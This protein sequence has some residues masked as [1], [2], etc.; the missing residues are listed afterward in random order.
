MEVAT[1]ARNEEQVLERR[2]FLGALAGASLGVLSDGIFTE[3]A[4]AQDTPHAGETLPAQ[5][6]FETSHVEVSGNTIFV[7][8]CGTGPAILLVHGFPRTSLMWRFL[9]PKLA[10]HHTVICADLRAYGGSGV[11][12]STGD[13]F[14]YSKRAMA[15]ELV[16]VM[17][18]LGFATFTLVGHDRGGRVSYRLAL[19][20]PQKS[21]GSRS[22]M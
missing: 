6:P 1:C 22:L 7:R 20:H 4:R 14:P 5:I 13:H 19:D 17:D 12:A 15:K 8:R 21:S 3:F 11:P 2:S 10:E 9:A 18:K 16:A